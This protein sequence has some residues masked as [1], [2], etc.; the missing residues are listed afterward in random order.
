MPPAESGAVL[1]ELPMEAAETGPAP[2]EAL[3]TG[4]LAYE[5]VDGA[6]AGNLGPSGAAAAQLPEFLEP[7]PIQGRSQPQTLHENVEE[8]GLQNQHGLL[9]IIH[10]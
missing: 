5:A 10:G 2:R 1:L 6:F 8:M 4:V 9:H 3:A 7:S